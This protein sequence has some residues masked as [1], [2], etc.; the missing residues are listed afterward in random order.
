VKNAKQ[1]ANKR[2][3][4]ASEE[5]KETNQRGTVVLKV[6]LFGVFCLEGIELLEKSGDR[7]TRVGILRNSAKKE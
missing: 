2:Q 1:R 6:S 5:K 4:L 7:R 3:V